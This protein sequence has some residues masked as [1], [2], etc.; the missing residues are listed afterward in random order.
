VEPQANTTLRMDRTTRLPAT[1]GSE[2]VQVAQRE[3]DY[4]LAG[5]LEE[6][7]NRVDSKAKSEEEITQ[8]LLGAVERTIQTHSS[9]ETSPSLASRC[10][11]LL[12]L[13]RRAKSL[14]ISL[15]KELQLSQAPVVHPD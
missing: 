9:E 15:D 4:E 13:C 11:A 3:F 6:I 2:A 8:N 1:Y 14:T 12:T 7:A 5:K 10:Q